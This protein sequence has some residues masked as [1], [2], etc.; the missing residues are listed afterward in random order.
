MEYID[1]KL[2]VDELII[3]PSLPNH[4]VIR[5][6]SNFYMLRHSSATDRELTDK[7]LRQYKKQPHKNWYRPTASYQYWIQGLVPR[8]GYQVEIGRAATEEEFSKIIADHCLTEDDVSL[9]F[10]DSRGELF[11]QAYS[12]SFPAKQIRVKTAGE[13]LALERELRNKGIEAANGSPDR[14]NIRVQSVK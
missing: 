5:I 1:G 4:V 9:E 2:I 6:D 10:T 11:G 7:D 3:D 14:V 13:A 8:G 12:K